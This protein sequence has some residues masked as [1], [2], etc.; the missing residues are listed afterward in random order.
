[1][2]P[3]Q[4]VIAFLILLA[5]S[6]SPIVWLWALKRDNEEKSAE[7][8]SSVLPALDAAARHLYGEAVGWSPRAMEDYDY[9]PKLQ[10]HWRREAEVARV[11]RFLG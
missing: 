3:L 5:L 2:S 7:P 9:S 6:F 10:D 8:L 11:H 4:S 1:M